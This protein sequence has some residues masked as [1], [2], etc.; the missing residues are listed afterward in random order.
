MI[1]K[2]LVSGLFLLAVGAVAFLTVAPGIVDKQQ[3]RNL[4]PGPY[5]APDAVQEFHDSL[6]IMDW[7]ADTLLWNRDMLAEHQRGH[8]DVPR[9]QRGNVALQM[10]T[11]VSRAPK[12]QNYVSTEDKNDLVTPLVIA[13]RWP[14]Y[15]WN[16]ARGRA[17]YQAEKLD[18]AVGL[19][20]R[21][22]RWVRNQGEL[23]VLLDE[24]A[25]AASG[26]YDPPV[27][28]LLGMEGA[29]T[30]EGDIRHLDEF[31]E[32]GYRMIGLTHF[33]DNELGGSLHGVEKGG[34]TELGRQFVKRANEP[35]IIIDISHASEKTVRDV[36]DLSTKP[37]VM[38]HGGLK[39]ACDTPRNIA[40]ELMQEIAARG[41][42]LAMGFWSGAICDPSAA[43]I[44]KTI[45]YAV[46]TVGVDH[47]ALGSDWDG[48]VTAMD[49]DNIAS[50]TAALLDLGMSRE[51]IAKVMGGNS[52]AFLQRWL[53]ET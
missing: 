16:S 43:S 28:A 46:K 38:S 35:G 12:G 31:Y 29:Q 7:H 32:L 5:D 41:G 27:G 53:P 21:K 18:R 34:L 25:R 14:T 13:Q 52:V 6:T 3:N 39:G 49:A 24:R 1:R 11:V 30:L 37:L 50:I 20:W 45:S 9:L 44:A 47:V 17:V 26:D 15:T 42:L 23:R 22:L 10:F 33:F 36:L 8:V 4:T 2:K 48:S 51:D 19:S 40:D